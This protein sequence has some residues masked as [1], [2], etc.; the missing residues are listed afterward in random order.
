MSVFSSNFI[1]SILIFASLIS[2][3]KLLEEKLHHTND[4][5]EKLEN[6]ENID[7]SQLY[8]KVDKIHHDIKKLREHTDKQHHAQSKVFNKEMEELHKRLE[9]LEADD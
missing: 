8:H 5:L 1:S 3:N 9:H 7:H 2:I 6:H 4:R